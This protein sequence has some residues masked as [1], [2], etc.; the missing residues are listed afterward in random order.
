MVWS[1]WTLLGSRGLGSTARS[2]MSRRSPAARRPSA[3]SCPTSCKPLGTRSGHRSDEAVQPSGPG[4]GH[5]L[6]YLCCR[7]EQAHGGVH[8][9]VRRKSLCYNV[10]VSESISHSAAASCALYDQGAGAEPA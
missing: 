2:D 3:R 4:P 7:Q 1:R 6:R 5:Q 10:I 8:I 9:H